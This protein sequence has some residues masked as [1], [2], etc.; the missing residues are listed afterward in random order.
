[1]DIDSSRI[2]EL[3]SRPGESLSVEVKAWID[4]DIPDGISKIVRAALAL[5]NHGGGYLVIGFDNDTLQPDKRNVPVRR[6]V[7]PLSVVY[8][9][10]EANR[11]E[12]CEAGLVHD[13]D[14]VQAEYGAGAEGDAAFRQVLRQIPSTRLANLS[15]VSASLIRD[16]RKGRRRITHST[17]AALERAVGEYLNPRP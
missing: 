1:M 8:I 3:I 11:L 16:I 2:Q 12:D 13:L 9:G 10:K 6:P 7:S 5:R 15:G 17:R 4:P 14:D